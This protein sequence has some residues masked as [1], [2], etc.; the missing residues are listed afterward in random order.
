[1]SD[2]SLTE[3]AE[4]KLAA[5][6]PAPVTAIARRLEEAGYQA[7]L[8]GGGVRDVLLAEL[9]RARGGSPGDW[10]LASNARPEQVLPLFKKVLPTGIQHGTVTVVLERQHYE[11]TTLRGERGFSDGRRPDEVFF[12]DDITADLARRDFTVNAIAFD[13]RSGRL[14]DPFDGIGDLQRNVL[15]AVGVAA[16][17]FAEDGLRVLRGA[18]FCSTLGMLLEEETRRAIRPSLDSFRKV[19]RERVRDEWW[20]ALASSAPSACF[21]IQRDEGLLECVAPELVLDEESLAA[22]DTAPARP[23]LRFAVLAARGLAGPADVRAA[24]TLELAQRLRLSNAEQKAASHW[25]R[26][27][28]VTLGEAGA[29]LRRALSAVGREAAPELLEFLPFSRQFGPDE[30]VAAWVAAA[31][32]V[33]SSGAPLELGD[34]AVSGRDLLAERVLSPGPRLGRLL[35]ALLERVLEEPS[36]NER[37]RLLELATELS[38]V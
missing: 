35:G 30:D 13:L 29:P 17:R 31:R 24:A 36:L 5:G 37:A 18:R 23:L 14:I 16:E 4:R 6:V 26:H 9:G 34:L 8:V 10:D 11:L 2:A 25:I 33:L 15:R 22:L 19:S 3:Q 28:D 32:D 1:M 38:R 12:V 21:R 7:W 20:K 27:A